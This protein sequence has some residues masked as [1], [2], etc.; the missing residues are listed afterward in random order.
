MSVLPVTLLI[1]CFNFYIKKIFI[2]NSN[3]NIS[4]TCV[5]F[6]HKSY[7]FF[8]KKHT[9]WLSLSVSA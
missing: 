4:K 5:S 7:T 8:K 3:R 2:L 1:P 9:F 6:N